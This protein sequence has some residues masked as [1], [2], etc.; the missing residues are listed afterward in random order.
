MMRKRN[1]QRKERERESE[2]LHME[3]GIFRAILW[4]ADYIGL[5]QPPLD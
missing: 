3:Y 4:E 2:L 5:F 1:M